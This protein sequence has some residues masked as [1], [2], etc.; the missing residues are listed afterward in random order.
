MKCNNLQFPNRNESCEK[1]NTKSKSE[2]FIKYKSMKKPKIRGIWNQI[3]VHLWWPL[4]TCSHWNSVSQIACVNTGCTSNSRVAAERLEEQI[5][6][7]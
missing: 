4:A 6:W 7:N 2:E 3:H 5:P 1:K